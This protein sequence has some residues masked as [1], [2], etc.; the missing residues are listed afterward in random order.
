MIIQSIQLLGVKP[1]Y[2]VKFCIQHLWYTNGENYGLKFEN[3]CL[4]N[5]SFDL[6][7]RTR[8]ELYGNWMLFRLAWSHSTHWLNHW[9]NLGTCSVLDT[10]QALAW[11]RSTMLQ[12]F[13]IMETWNLG[14]TLLWTNTRIFGLNMWIMIWSLCRC[15][16]SEF[17]LS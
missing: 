15:A 4:I 8:I 9:T 17:R 14:S 2:N 16:I 6:L 5:F 11:M 10:I 3:G 13:I 1:I 7:I 12:S